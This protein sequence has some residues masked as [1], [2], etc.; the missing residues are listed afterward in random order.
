MFASLAIERELRRRGWNATFRATGQTGIFISGDGVSVDAVVADFIA[1]AAE[2]LSPSTLPEHWDII[3]GQGCLH[4]PAYAGVTLSLIHGSQPDAMV[5]CHAIGRDFIDGFP[6]Y[7]VP[8]L[9]EAIAVNE[10]AARLTNARAQVIGIC[11][12]TSSVSEAAAREYFATVERKLNL[13]CCDPVRTGVNAIV[14][15]LAELVDRKL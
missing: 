9:E 2:T 6:A 15:R 10:R 5:L 11:V 1:G 8:T 13:P 12:N 3:E 7:R 4:H 14:D